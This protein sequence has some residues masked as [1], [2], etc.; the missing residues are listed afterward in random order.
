[1]KEILFLVVSYPTNIN[2]LDCFT[3]DE[4]VVFRSAKP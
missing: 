4:L 1:M 2:T 3:G